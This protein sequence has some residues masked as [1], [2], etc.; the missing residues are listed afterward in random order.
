V[1]PEEIP[2]KHKDLSFLNRNLTSIAIAIIKEMVFILNVC[3]EG[4]REAVRTFG[5]KRRQT[6]F[7]KT[8]LSP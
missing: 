1:E 8:T 2:G 5:K 4:E 6:V 7:S 3:L